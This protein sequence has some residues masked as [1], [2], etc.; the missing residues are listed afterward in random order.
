MPN[1]PIPHRMKHLPLDHRGYPT[2]VIVVVKDG[3]PVFSVNDIDITNRMIQEDRCSICGTKLFRGRWLVGGGLSGLS[4]KGKFADG[5]LHDEC[6]HYALKVC[7][8]LAAPNW[9]TPIGKFQHAAAGIEGAAFD[10]KDSI[11]VADTQRPEAFVAVMASKIDI[12]IRPFGVLLC[13]PKEGHVMRAEVWRNGTMLQ[14]ADVTDF[15]ER[16]RPKVQQYSAMRVDIC[17]HL[18]A[19]RV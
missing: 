8:Y 10:L 15:I 16:M 7:P 14:G 4:E 11:T 9:K 2:P 3:K 13:R 19:N 12:E 17:K 6:A 5:P 18:T 1:V